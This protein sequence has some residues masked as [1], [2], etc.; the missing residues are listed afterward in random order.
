MEI[1]HIILIIALTVQIYNLGT[2][3]FCQIVVYPLFGKVGGAE[4]VDYHHHYATRIPLPI[5]IPGFASFFLPFFVLF[6]LPASVPAWMAWANV[7]CGV[8][9]FLVTVALEIPRHNKLERGGKNDEL[10]RQLIQFNWP[11]TWSITVS[12]ALTLAMAL[13]AFAPVLAQN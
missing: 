7:L 8:V 4:Y 1:S 5:I 3:W 13:Q 9:G 2:I 6:F 10:I 11:R 12:A